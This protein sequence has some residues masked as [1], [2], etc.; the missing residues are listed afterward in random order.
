[1]R[2]VLAGLKE[3]GVTKIAAVGY[4]Y[5]ARLGFNL[6]FDNEITVLATSHPSLLQIPTDIEVRDLCCAR[7]NSV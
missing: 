7:T 1:M 2:K 4:C 3:G 6:A 5:G